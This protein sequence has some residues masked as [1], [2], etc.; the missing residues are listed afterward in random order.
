MVAQHQGFG[1]LCGQSRVSTMLPRGGGSTE[2]GTLL[3]QSSRVSAC[4]RRGPSARPGSILF[5]VSCR[6]SSSCCPGDAE[7]IG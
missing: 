7:G 4:S 6:I 3:T 1:H 5:T 2:G